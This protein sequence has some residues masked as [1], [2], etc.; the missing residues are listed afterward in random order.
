M[1]FKQLNTNLISKLDTL[2]S[3]LSYNPLNVRK[4]ANSTQLL[5]VNEIRTQILGTQ[6]HFGP[7]FYLRI[8]MCGRRI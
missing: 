8:I 4:N 3:F 6:V 1:Y 7:K 5:P 2:I